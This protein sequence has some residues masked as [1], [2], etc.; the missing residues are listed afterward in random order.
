MNSPSDF[1]LTRDELARGIRRR[2]PHV[3]PNPSDCYVYC[4]ADELAAEGYS[5]VREVRNLDAR[6]R[7]NTLPTPEHDDTEAA[8]QVPA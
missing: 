1:I 3:V 7:A 6:I 2:A 4:L 8:E 5:H